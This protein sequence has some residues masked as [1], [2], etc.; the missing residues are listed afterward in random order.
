VYFNFK[1]AL[2][3]RLKVEVEDSLAKN[4]RQKNCIKE[5][6]HDESSFCRLNWTGFYLVMLVYRATI[7]E[8]QSTLY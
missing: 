5:A 8:F 4:L 1:M 3:L 6:R 7:V 2:H